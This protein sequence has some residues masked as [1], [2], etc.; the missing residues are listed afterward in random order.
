MMVINVVS[1]NSVD[2]ERDIIL[3][4]I[5]KIL[6]YIS[7]TLAIILSVASIFL[8]NF[9]HFNSVA[10]I[11]LVGVL[12]VV[13]GLITMRSAFLIGTKQFKIFSFNT[14]LNAVLRLIF[15]VLFV[16]IGWRVFGAISGLLIAQLVV[17]VYLYYKTRK[18]I[19]FIP[20]GQ[21]VFTERV[22]R[23]LKFGLMVLAVMFTVTFFY[24]ADVLF[25][26][27]LFIAEAAGG[28]SGIATIARIIYFISGPA[29]GVLFAS[30]GVGRHEE[31]E[32]LAKKALI[33]VGV[34][35]LGCLFLFSFFPS[36]V[37]QLSLG[38]NYLNYSF[39]LPRVGLL[40]FLV[41][42]MNA[43]L[44]Y[45]LAL[46]RKF[47]VWLGLGGVIVTSSLMFLSHGSLFNLV[48]NFIIGVLAVLVCIG[49]KILKPWGLRFIRNYN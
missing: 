25:A 4:E 19:N 10:P 49:I 15:A 41:S 32:R 8:K 35:G 46:R 26:K 5:K 18:N 9:F 34:V 6:L 1:N 43:F 17:L 44:M 14:I 36:L 22:G 30:V 12:V 42:I 20:L 28:Y 39:L 2:F 21:T 11:I 16:I 45:Y 13:S 38:K 23:E 31:N 29:I 37:V 33:V 24:S 7:L 40:L 48:N 3:S 47:V 27:R